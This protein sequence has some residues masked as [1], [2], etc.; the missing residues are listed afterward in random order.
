[1][2]T[3]VYSIYIKGLLTNQEMLLKFESQSP[4]NYTSQIKR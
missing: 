3:C 4:T 1:M 2:Q